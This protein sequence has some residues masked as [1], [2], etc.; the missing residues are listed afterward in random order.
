VFAAFFVRQRNS[1]N[2]GAI[3]QNTVFYATVEHKV[4]AYNWA[5]GPSKPYDRQATPR[6]SGSNIS[7]RVLSE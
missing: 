4:S 7:T 3:R 2:G 5:E 1:G 6:S